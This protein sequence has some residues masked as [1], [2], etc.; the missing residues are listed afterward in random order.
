LRDNRHYTHPEQFPDQ[1]NLKFPL[2]QSDLEI[3]EENLNLLHKELLSLDSKKKELLFLK[4][5]SG[6]TYNEIGQLLEF[7]PDTVKKQVY[8]ILGYLKS[9][10]KSKMVNLFLMSF[11]S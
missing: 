6:L 2:E 4:F 1:F 9:K 11:R 8:R 3:K 5:N 10:L 7:N